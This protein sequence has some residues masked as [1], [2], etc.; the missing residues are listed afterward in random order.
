MSIYHLNSISDL[1]IDDIYEIFR[2]S[3]IIGNSNT[4]HDYKY[5]LKDKIVMN[6]FLEHSTRTALSFEIASKKLSANVVNF[7]SKSSS[8]NKGENLYDT[9]D[10]LLAYAPDY[11]II[12]SPHSGIFHSVL[13]KL[14]I[15]SAN[16]NIFVNAGDGI[17]EHPTQ[18]LIDLYT[19]IKNIETLNDDIVKSTISPAQRLIGN[20]LFP[21]LSNLKIAICGDIL[22]SR[23][24]HS[25]IKLFSLFNI[26]PILIG[27][28]PL[29][30]AYLDDF[31]VYFSIDEALKLNRLDIIIML[32]VQFERMKNNN[33]INSNSEYSKFWG[34][35]A[36][37]IYDS[38]NPNMK[39]M[40]PGPV[41]RGV[42][43]SEDV[44]DSYAENLLILR[45]VEY[46]I[47]I[48]QAVM[49]FL[50]MKNFHKP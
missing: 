44:F 37:K 31:E 7:C 47:R 42:E 13:S 50:E 8:M 33:Y 38:L 30:S 32:R 39:I 6:V 36:Q 25:D 46:S 9:L 34:I 35:N 28:L 5:I 49:V 12:R 14:N 41:N 2:I 24:A 4:G 10:T 1:E 16:N 21:D 18:A 40:H 23:V 15:N 17:N 45:Q 29:V 48:R 20:H 43:I 22:N 11:C 26:K 27:P 3:D 19:I